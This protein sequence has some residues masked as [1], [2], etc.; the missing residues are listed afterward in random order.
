MLD[1]KDIQIISQLL[2]QQLSQQKKEIMEELRG[3]MDTRFTQQKKEIRSEIMHE[4]RLLMENYFDPKFNALTDD[5]ELLKEKVIGREGLEKL[6]ENSDR[7]D[8]LEA[9]VKVH[10]REIETLKKS[11][12]IA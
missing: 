10:T 11:N 12:H 2:N 4:V 7:L 6:E 9:A 5:L 3:E 8:V 1:E